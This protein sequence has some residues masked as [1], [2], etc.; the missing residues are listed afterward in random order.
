MLLIA[1]AVDQLSENLIEVA[2]VPMEWAVI[3]APWGR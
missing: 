1:E 2:Q 3:E